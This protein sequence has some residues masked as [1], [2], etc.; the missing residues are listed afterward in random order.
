MRRQEPLAFLCSNK[1][2]L[3]Y[4]AIPLSRYGEETVVA[5]ENVNQSKLR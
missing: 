2:E 3:P 5:V 1:V 4:P